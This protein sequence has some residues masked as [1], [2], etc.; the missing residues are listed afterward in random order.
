[1]ST[2]LPVATRHH[3]DMTEK[4]LKA[5]LNKNK[6]QQQNSWEKQPDE[7]FYLAQQWFFLPAS[8]SSCTLN[9]PV[10]HISIFYFNKSQDSQKFWNNNGKYFSGLILLRDSI[11]IQWVRLK[12]K[13]K[14][15]QRVSASCNVLNIYEPG[16]EKMRHVIC[17]QQG[18]RSACA[19][20]QSD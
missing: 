6:Q 14:K 7:K 9:F 1:M 12:V 8:P 19:S 18:R 16:H 13:K 5:T 4:L 11:W 10:G 15:L 20:A 3:H 2:E 17:E